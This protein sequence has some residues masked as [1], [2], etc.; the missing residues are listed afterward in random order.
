MG[1]GGIPISRVKGRSLDKLWSCLGVWGKHMPKHHSTTAIE[2]G[3]T[4]PVLN[5]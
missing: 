4:L 1:V 2:E 3:I 5:S